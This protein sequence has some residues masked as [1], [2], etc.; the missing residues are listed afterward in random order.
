[1]LAKIE[2]ERSWIIDFE[3]IVNSAGTKKKINK[4]QLIT[5]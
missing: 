3:S 2:H 4:D 1:M 5:S